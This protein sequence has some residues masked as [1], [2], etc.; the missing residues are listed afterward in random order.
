MKRFALA[1]ILIAAACRPHHEVPV[2]QWLWR[3]DQAWTSPPGKNFRIAPA[4]VLAFRSGGEYA[5]LHCWVLE[6]PDETVYIATNTPR[7][8]VV[9]QWVQQ[10]D[11]IN[12][13]RSQMAHSGRGTAA[14]D[15]CAHPQ[16]TFHFSGSS[17]TGDPSGTGDA[18]YSPVTRLVAP[19]F[20]FY[21]KEAR[22]SV[23]CPPRQ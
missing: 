21:V 23:P 17:L 7:T 16:V 15:P 11:A 5:E 4:T 18:L 10:K 9:G 12:I 6:R 14:I 19:D 20:E 13:T 8:V 22:K 1:A 2:G 3:L